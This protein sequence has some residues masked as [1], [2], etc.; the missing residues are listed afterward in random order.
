M[1]LELPNLAHNAFDPKRRAA[2]VS[3]TFRRLLDHFERQVFNAPPENI[4]DH[5]MSA[6][7]QL[8]SGK[9]DVAATSLVSMPV[10]NLLADPKGSRAFLRRQLQ[11]EGVR[12]YLI[13][14]YA[15][16][17]SI[18]L[19]SIASRFALTA[20][21]AHA[22]LS[23]MMLATEL[24]AS[25]DQP[26]SSV[27]VQR[28]EPSKLQFLALQLAEKVALFID[29]N[30]HGIEGRTG[31][32]GNKIH[33]FYERRGGYDGSQRERRPWVERSDRYDGAGSR[34]WKS[35]HYGGDRVGH[36]DRGAGESGGRR[37]NSYLGAAG[38]PSSMYVE[39]R[40]G[41]MGGSRR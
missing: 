15:H 16:Y 40:G 21:E 23:K 35:A 3:R 18:S 22:I 41:S 36:S 38:R 9:W 24:D 27:V 33:D 7:Q 4:R 11:V 13:S 30:E 8:L 37:G 31:L 26:A 1:L 28:I 14:S 12:A 29:T 20:E 17:D 6:S 34:P 5:I 2:A 10:W 19:P 25:W 39:R 32:F